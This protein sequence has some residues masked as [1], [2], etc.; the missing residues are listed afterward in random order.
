MS[1]S[2]AENENGAGETL[3]VEGATGKPTGERRRVGFVGAPGK[4]GSR[5][6]W[7]H[8]VK[9]FAYHSSQFGLF[10]SLKIQRY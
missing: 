10:L 6:V 1:S 8:V 9:R 2:A 3:L 5:L 4:S 7:D